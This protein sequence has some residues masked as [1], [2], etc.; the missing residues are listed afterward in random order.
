MRIP[1]VGLPTLRHQASPHAA[2]APAMDAFV[3]GASLP[4]AARTLFEPV[5]PLW[6]HRPAMEAGD[7]PGGP[8]LLVR[9]GEVLAATERTLTRLGG[10]D[11]K[12]GWT[13]RLQSPDRFRERPPIVLGQDLLGYSVARDHTGRT[14]G[15]AVVDAKAGHLLRTVQEESVLAS[16]VPTGD[17]GFVLDSQRFTWR[18]GD[19]QHT[20][21]ACGE[22]LEIAG[23]AASLDGRRLVLPGADGSVSVWEV[24]PPVRTVDPRPLPRITEGPG[25]IR[26]GDVLLPCA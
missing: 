7:R 16:P 13:V 1:P 5:R 14:T 10:A 18:D 20:V 26:I 2:P 24:P 22:R 21:D 19:L 23:H 8:P 17:G 6:V 9:G 25:W 3:Q 4:Q 12:P 11:G 15:V